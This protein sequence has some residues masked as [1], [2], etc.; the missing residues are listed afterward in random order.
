MAT[1]T[2]TAAAPV[3]TFQSSKRIYSVDI[4]RGLTIIAMVWANDMADL[5]PVKSPLP[6]VA[7]PAVPQ[8]MKHMVPGVDGFTFVDLII[9]I[10]MF[11]LGCS[12]PLALGKRLAQTGSIL[13]VLGHVLIRSVSLMIMGLFDV[14]RFKGSL[15]PSY[16]DMLDWPH[17]LWR[18]LAWTCIFIVWLDFPLQA[19]DPEKRSRQIAKREGARF[20][21]L[22]GLVWLAV[23]FRSSIGDPPKVGYFTTSWWGTLGQLGW[24]Y[25]AASLV[26]IMFRNRR[27]GIL[28]VFVLMH[29]VFLGWVTGYL[30][31]AGWAR[32]VGRSTLTTYAAN[33]IAG[34]CIGTLLYEGASH[35]KSIRWA[36]IMAACT[37]IAVLVLRAISANMLAS[38]EA[39]RAQTPGQPESVIQFAKSF[40]GATNLHLPSTAWS[41]SAT[42]IALVIWALLYWVTDVRGLFTRVLDPLRTVGQNSLMIYQFA[43]Y[44]I[45]VYWL[46]GL[47]FY[48]RLA[49]PGIG[50]VRSL[51]Y[52]L[53][54]AALTYVL[55]KKRVFLKV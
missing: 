39:L 22:M 13:S 44:G 31:V 35:W 25:L 38:A 12:I 30:P 43:R 26:W 15:G 33:T 54:L 41:L 32:W 23:V 3:A 11:L 27:F 16:G 29:L 34:L 20:A 52:A 46:T 24:A 4:L 37:A 28:T 10:F 36:L 55:T 53:L 14:N 6:G 51:C 49:T 8:W 40:S 17:G 19:T 7:S 48:D 9:P 50:I 18:F 45:L 21:A 2:L 42:S 47:T 5:I 1:A